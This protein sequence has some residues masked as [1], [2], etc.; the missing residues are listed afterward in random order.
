MQGNVLIKNG[1]KASVAR[2][3]PILNHTFPKHCQPL[4]PLEV[5]QMH[6][7]LPCKVTSGVK[8]Q[9]PCIFLFHISFDAK[10]N[11]ARV[12]GWKPRKRGEGWS[13]LLFG[14]R[15][16]ILAGFLSPLSFAVERK[17]AGSGG[18]TPRK[19]GLG[20]E[21]PRPG[22]LYNLAKY[23]NFTVNFFIL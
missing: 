1:H 9:S 15:D 10:R 22:F 19:W 7:L 5:S 20:A 21:R 6:G 16:V 14:G 17:G 4:A 3:W 8:G 2:L 13:T 11:T 12:R 18:G 23:C